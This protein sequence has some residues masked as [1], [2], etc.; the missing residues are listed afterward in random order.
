MWGLLI[1][2]PACLLAVDRRNPKN[3]HAD[4]CA[5][6]TPGNR[7]A[8]LA[9]D[10]IPVQTRSEP[11]PGR[12]ALH[13]VSREAAPG[14]AC[15]AHS[16]AAAA[17]PSERPPSSPPPSAWP[18]PPCLYERYTSVAHLQHSTAQH[19][20]GACPA[21][22]ARSAAAFPASLRLAAATLPVRA[23]H[24]SCAFAAQH[25][26]RLAPALLAQRTL[27]PRFPPPCAWPLPPCLH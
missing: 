4:A 16:A 15:A 10:D 17:P 24:I 9:R 11:C 8:R 25:S 26:M 6:E 27:Q 23:V 13:R 18:P 7:D 19:A 2:W 12:V 22:A 14:P 1:S 21:C 20:A 3:R 5:A